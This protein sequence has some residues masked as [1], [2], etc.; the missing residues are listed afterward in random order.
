MGI[1]NFFLS[2]RRKG[3]KDQ[4]GELPIDIWRLAGLLPAK[5]R[6]HDYY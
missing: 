3:A 2:Q 4:G 6:C 5:P 1:R